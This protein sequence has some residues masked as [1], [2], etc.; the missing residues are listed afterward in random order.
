MGRCRRWTPRRVGQQGD[1]PLREN[2]RAIPNGIKRE[3]ARDDDSWM[4]DEVCLLGGV[5]D[6]YE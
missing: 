3:N 1:W 5:V 2:M 6:S 4:K